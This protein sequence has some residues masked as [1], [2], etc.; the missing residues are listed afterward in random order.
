MTE[1]IF[2]II[3]VAAF[4]SAALTTGALS[5]LLMVIGVLALLIGGGLFVWFDL[6]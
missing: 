1:I 4:I 2:L 6:E 5:F 3:A